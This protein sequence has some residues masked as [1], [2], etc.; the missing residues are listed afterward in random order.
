VIRT[1]ATA[2]LCDA[3]EEALRN[4]QLQLAGPGLHALG[5]RPAFC[6]QAVTLKLFEDNSLVAESVAQPGAGRVLVVDGAGSLRTAL[7]G[8]NLARSAEQNGWAGLVIYGAVRDAA[9]IDACDLGVRALGTCPRRS[10]KRGAGER[11]VLVAFLGVTIRPG[12]WLY[13]DRDGLL[14]SER[15]LHA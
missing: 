2:D 13:A 1:P 10:V 11:D 8:G 14:V 7:V 3:H 5:R 9:E 15:A 12:D 4:G 6:G